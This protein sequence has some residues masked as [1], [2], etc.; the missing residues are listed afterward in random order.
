[1]DL[2]IGLFS[3]R[4]KRLLAGEEGMLPLPVAA[5]EHIH[6]L[7]TGIESISHSLEAD[8]KVDLPRLLLQID[9]DNDQNGDQGCSKELCDALVGLESKFTDIK[10]QLHQVQPRYNIDFSLWMGEL[11]IMCLLHLQRD[12]MMSLQDDAMVELL[13]QLIEGPLQLSVV[14]IIDSCGLEILYKDFEKRKTAL[15]DYLKNKRYLIVLYDVFTN[16]VWDYLGEAL[17]DHQNGSRVLVILFDDEIFNLCILENEDMINLDSVPAT[18]LRA[19]YQERPLVCLY[20]GS[21]SLAENMK[22]TWLIRKRSP[23]FSIAQLPQRLKLCCLY[24]SACREGFEISTRQLNQL[25]IAEGFIPETARKL[26]S[27]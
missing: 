16:D 22:L 7:Q 1:M 23:L 20:Y 2:H 5:K 11:K 13:D 17:P 15:H 6:N 4:L 24:L 19:T 3:E 18:P 14:A 21:E 27:T 9:A 25:W 26:L 8:Y 12:N 10:Q